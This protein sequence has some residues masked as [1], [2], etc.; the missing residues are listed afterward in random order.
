VI[1]NCA[2]VPDGLLHSVLFGHRR[3]A[4]TSAEEDRAGVFE[5]AH[6]GTLFLDEVGDMSMAVQ[7]A[8]LR[9]LEDG[10]V[11]RVGETKARHVDV[12]IVSA[13]H[14]DLRTRIQEGSFR[15]DLYYRLSTFQIDVP[16][17]RERRGDVRLLARHFIEIWNGRG[18]KTI[19]G[20]TDE[21]MKALEAYSWPGNVRQLR[22]E[23]ERACILTAEFAAIHVDS[24]SDAVRFGD[25]RDKSAADPG[26]PVGTGLSEI[27][28][29][30]ERTAL[31][32][33]LLRANG[34]KTR[35]AA[36][37]G[38]SRQRLSYRLKQHGLD[39]RPGA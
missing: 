38:I 24:I 16:P 23:I 28:R 35:A 30:T 8:V 12:R 17:L 13:T 11:V 34:N 25:E 22:S 21:A 31:E 6:G 5:A 9:A 39:Y 14:Y 33:A 26:G 19:A 2:A 32:R 37:L 1:K 3:G 4:F 20:L 18:Q 29:T 27:M 7:G 10:E 15:E 36:L